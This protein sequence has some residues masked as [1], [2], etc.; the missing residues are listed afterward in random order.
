MWVSPGFPFCFYDLIDE[1]GSELEQQSKDSCR[2]EAENLLWV[3]ELKHVRIRIK[4]P[5]SEFLPYPL[6]TPSLITLCW[7]D[8]SF[9]N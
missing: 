3:R 7:N 6:L 9:G 4:A 8:I 2:E 1:M 5:P